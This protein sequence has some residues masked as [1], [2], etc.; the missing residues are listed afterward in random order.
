M[1]YF[2]DEGEK[3]FFAKKV[4]SF[5]ENEKALINTNNRKEEEQNN[6]KEVC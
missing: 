4:E 3:D 1:A 5:Q 6:K 2:A